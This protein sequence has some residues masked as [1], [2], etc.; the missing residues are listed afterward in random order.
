MKEDFFLYILGILSYIVGTLF[1]VGG[2][3][4]MAQ[5]GEVDLI[6]VGIGIALVLVGYYWYK[7]RGK[8]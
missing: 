4:K 7:G 2:L 1:I 5:G 8:K 6:L 3:N